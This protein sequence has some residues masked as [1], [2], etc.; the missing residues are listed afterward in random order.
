MADYDIIGVPASL[1]IAEGSVRHFHEEKPYESYDCDVIL[2]AEYIPPNVTT[3]DAHVKGLVI[4]ESSILC[5][6][7]CIARELHIPCVVGIED[8]CG[9]LP[10]GRLVRIDGENGGISYV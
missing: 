5:H 3:L 6:A 9:R 8:V 2:A 4:E 10:E 1:G 7:A